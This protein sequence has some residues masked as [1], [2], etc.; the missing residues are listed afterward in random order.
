M[1]ARGGRPGGGIGEDGQ[2]AERVKLL[3]QEKELR[4]EL[5]ERLTQGRWA[6]QSR[7]LCAGG[8]DV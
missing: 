3:E 4:V 1:R 8:R 6:V 5:G 7:P 2:P